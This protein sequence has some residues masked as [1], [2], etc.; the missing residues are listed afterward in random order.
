M[1]CATHFAQ[2]WGTFA[3][4]AQQQLLV[5]VCQKNGHDLNVPEIRWTVL[6]LLTEI[7]K[8]EP[9][10]HQKIVEQVCGKKKPDGSGWEYYPLNKR[11]N[12]KHPTVRMEF[13]SLM[14]VM[15]ERIVM[16][17]RAASPADLL[18][19]IGL[20]Q[21]QMTKVGVHENKV[22]K[23]LVR[24]MARSFLGDLCVP[25]KVGD[26]VQTLWLLVGDTAPLNAV[27][28]AGNLA[29][30]IEDVKTAVTIVWGLWTKLMETGR[31][32]EFFT[33]EDF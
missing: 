1:G 21:Q 4:H 8:R 5:H 22:L 28:L 9:G 32:A 6:Q 14:E 15:N 2:F 13:L 27:A 19:Q 31:T 17:A 16:T 26:T 7:V 10:A 23:A 18:A 25:E 12:D 24:K 11:L 20:E 29:H 30:S 3:P 33:Q